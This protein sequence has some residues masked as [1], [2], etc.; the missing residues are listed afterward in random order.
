MI[1]STLVGQSMT[2][3]QIASEMQSSRQMTTALD[4]YM[5]ALD[6]M[7]AALPLDTNPRAKRSLRDKLKEIKERYDLDQVED[8]ADINSISESIIHAAIACAVALKKSP[9]PDVVTSAMNYAVFSI[10]TIDKILCVR[11]R[12]W[13]L[14]SC[15]VA[16][17]TQ[18]DRHYQ[19]HQMIAGAVYTSAMAIFKAGVAYTETPGYSE[20][21]DHKEL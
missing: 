1:N 12:T 5:V 3:I 21:K 20:K 10:N 7:M 11:E 18:V 13:Q 14:V 9:I 19:L 15:G 4:L 17:L 2:L 8:D 16:K 6:K